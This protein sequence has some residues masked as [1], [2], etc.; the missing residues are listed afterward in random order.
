MTVIPPKKNSRTKGN[1]APKRPIRL[2]VKKSTP[3]ALPP[4]LPAIKKSNSNIL[5][6]I[7]I[8]SQ[9]ISTQK[10]H[11][12]SKASTLAPTRVPPPPPSINIKPPITA[13]VNAF[14]KHTPLTSYPYI[15]HLDK[16]ETYT[17]AALTAKA[18]AAILKKEAQT[19]I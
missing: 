10:K 11:K 4:P 7:L 15:I 5:P 14:L 3:P 12:L 1:K 8:T 13:H 16:P 9:S 17:L 19:G 18:Q 2:T 6:N